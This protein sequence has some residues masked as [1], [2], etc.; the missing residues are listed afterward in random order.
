M[1]FQYDNKDANLA[2]DKERGLVRIKDQS[3]KNRYN[4]NEFV[5]RL[6]QNV[7]FMSAS[8]NNSPLI[9]YKNVMMVDRDTFNAFVLSF[10]DLVKQFGYLAGMLKLR[11]LP[12]I[13][14]DIDSFV[15]VFEEINKANYSDQ[16]YE[17]MIKK[18]AVRFGE[19]VRDS[20]N[21]NIETA[22]ANGIPLENPNKKLDNLEK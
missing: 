3:A 8:E 22:K 20:I 14:P 21:Y 16:N 10:N 7:D 19:A 1:A 11:C 9:A 17:A 5:A 6:R 13:L 2:Y 18:E 15:R 4:A 12:V